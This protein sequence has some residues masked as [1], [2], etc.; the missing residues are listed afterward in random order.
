MARKKK[1]D[2]TGVTERKPGEPEKVGEAKRDA[3]NT[4]REWWLA[5]P[6]EMADSIH[7]VI[8]T[9]KDRSTRLESQRLLSARLYGNLSLF[10]LQ[11]MSIS[12][13][14]AVQP[15][16]RDRITYNVAASAVDTVAAKMAK[17]KPKPLFLTDGTDHRVQ[18][19]AKK[20]TKFCEGMFYENRLRQMAPR[21]FK[22]GAILSDGFLHIFER[23][24]RVCMERV[25]CHEIYVDDIEAFYGTPRQM[26]RVRNVDRQLMIEWVKSLPLSAAE[27]KD[28][29]AALKSAETAVN[30]DYSGFDTKSI[31]D[32]VSV[33]QSW[34]LPSGP[35][36]TDGLCAISLPNKL[37]W[38]GEWKHDFFPFARFPWSPPLYGYWSRGLVESIQNIQLEMNKLLWLIQRSMHL[39]GTFKI[40][41][42]L[43]S[44]VNTGHLN[45]DIGTIIWY[46]QQAPVYLSPQVVPAEYYQHFE[47]LKASA[48]DQA[49]ISELSATSEK[50][51][52]LNSGKALREYEDIGSDRF[53]L[54]G[55]QY[56]EFH[57]E[58][59]R[60]GIAIARDISKSTGNG[61]PVKVPG[62]RFLETIDWMDID[63]EDDSYIMQVYP[64]SSLPHD[65]AGRTA[66]VQEW[67]QAGLIPQQMAA[68]LLDFP[69]LEEYDSL[70]SSMLDYVQ[71]TLDDIVDEGKYEGPDPA[72][73]DFAFARAMAQMYYLRGKGQGLAEDRL[74]MLQDWMNAC[75][76][77]TVK[78]MPPPPPGLPGA[79]PQAVPQ[80]PPQSD[81][82]PN[83]PS[84]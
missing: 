12:R 51:A 73:G 29:V 82:L 21:V 18:R 81:L 16:M 38:K 83:A 63:L 28:A 25:L 79:A 6:A 69:D 15:A 84:A 65:P 35:E 14:S 58:A 50:P 34:H 17:N 70:S 60:I 46:R 31:A 2:H 44:K 66:Q 53:Q 49:G 26:H 1:M 76:L 72:V 59:A 74:L 39:M 32:Q 71:L 52:G 62:K 41:L 40:A 8:E 24:G 22:E 10:G 67:V 23:F 56:E 75:D 77:L 48:Y 55:Q 20:L 7:G 9:I 78:S 27:M 57:M 54:I 5:S 33:A 19:K 68:R 80:P 42:E 3:G 4:T 13:A 36:A 45:N 47:R 43:G 64:I 11:G 30:D 61:Y 37:L